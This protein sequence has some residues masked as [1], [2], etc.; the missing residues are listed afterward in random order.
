M[1]TPTDD[2]FVDVSVIAVERLRDQMPHIL[3]YHTHTDFKFTNGP[4]ITV[5]GNIDIAHLTLCRERH[6][7]KIHL[8]HPQSKE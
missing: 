8:F 4:Y 2:Q 3:K 7:F 6:D 1:K 5:N